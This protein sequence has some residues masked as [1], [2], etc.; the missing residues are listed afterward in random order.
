ML[1][2]LEEDAAA[3]LEA[4]D[5]PASARKEIA[6]YREQIT[7]LESE[8]E[9]QVRWT[10]EDRAEQWRHDNLTVLVRGLR[11]LGIADPEESLLAA[12][13]PLNPPYQGDFRL[14]P[15]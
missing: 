3:R 1:V 14:L 5:D 10:F 15:P 9:E 2:L 13:N 8:V 7:A 6:S 11:A 4:L 12:P